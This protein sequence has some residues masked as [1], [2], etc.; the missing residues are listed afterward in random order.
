MSIFGSSYGM[1]ANRTPRN[2][3]APTP[4]PVADPMTTQYNL[5]N[6]AVQQQAG[7]YDS[8][9]KG[10]QGL[11]NRGPS[12]DTA[13][14]TANLGNLATTG[15]LS[16]EDEANLR[17]RGVSP[18]R[19]AYSTAMRNTDRQRGLQGGYSPNYGAVQAKMAREQ[20]EQLAQGNTNVEAMIAELRQRGRLGAAGT[21]ASAANSQDNYQRDAL[22]GM[23]SL[24]GTTPALSSL[25][26][27]QANQ[28][29]QL[30]NQINQQGVQNQSQLTDQFIRGLGGR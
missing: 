19:A 6:T 24:Y 7:D 20:S 30:Q 28:G 12:P 23:T 5:H 13:S 18:I 8:I 26:G 16:P 14:A 25:Y 22:H 10:Y 3:F 21:Y 2:I 29:A 27:S 15:G 9:M 1:S 17:A 4:P 11:L